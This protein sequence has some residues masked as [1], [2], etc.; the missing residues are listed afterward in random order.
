MSNYSDL[1]LSGNIVTDLS[2][3]FSLFCVIQPMMV[4]NEVQRY[5]IRDYSNFSD[6]LFIQDIMLTDWLALV[7]RAG[8][9]SSKQ[10]SVFYKKL[11]K[12]VHK[13]PP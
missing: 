3:H 1:L 12:L 4:K 2:D 13:H 9:D 8:N 11:N 5:K 10:F 7:T 6:A